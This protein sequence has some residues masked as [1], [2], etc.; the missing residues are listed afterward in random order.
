ME[1]QQLLKE[2]EEERLKPLLEANRLESMVKEKYQESLKALNVMIL[3][4]RNSSEK[5]EKI[6][7]TS[8]LSM[9]A[10]ELTELNKQNASRLLSLVDASLKQ[11]QEKKDVIEQLMVS[12][13]KKIVELRAQFSASETLDAIAQAYEYIDGDKGRQEVARLFVEEFRA[14]SQ[15]VMSKIEVIME[16]NL[17]ETTSESAARDELHQTLNS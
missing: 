7:S 14:V 16:D 17:R 8:T 11:L 12:A 5:L 3:E 15:E 1:R 2:Q 9:V 10:T 13:N 4:G 6:V